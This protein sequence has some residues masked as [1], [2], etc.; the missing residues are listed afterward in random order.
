MEYECEICG[1][2]RYLGF[3]PQINAKIY[4]DCGNNLNKNQNPSNEKLETEDIG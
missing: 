3:T 1:C 2:I 4:C